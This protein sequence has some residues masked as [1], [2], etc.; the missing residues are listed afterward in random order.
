MDAVRRIV[1][2]IWSLCFLAGA[3][4]HARQLIGGGWHVYDFAPPL[5]AL[6]WTA[7]L[8]IDLIVVA[9]LWTRRAAGVWLGLAVMIADVGANSWFAS[10]AGFAVLTMAL[11]LQTLFLGFTIGSAAL[12]LTNPADPA[13]TVGDAN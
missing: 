10:H 9:L 7:L 1:L 5:L 6:F 2:S 12:L 8:P 11:Q 4:N 13:S 3:F